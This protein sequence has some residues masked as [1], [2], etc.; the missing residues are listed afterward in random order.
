MRRKRAENGTG[1]CAEDDDVEF[2]V[3]GCRIDMFRDKLR[4]MRVHGS[5]LLYVHRTTRLI[6][7]GSP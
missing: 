4:S 6:R 7:T 5:V 3:L 1:I 2:N